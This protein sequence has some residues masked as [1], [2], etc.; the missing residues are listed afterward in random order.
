[1]QPV[2][3]AGDVGLDL[4]DQ[5]VQFWVGLAGE[6]EAATSSNNSTA[7]ARAPVPAAGQFSRTASIGCGPRRRGDIGSWHGDRQMQNGVRLTFDTMR[8]TA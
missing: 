6:G 5:P 3:V 1:M 2:D 4:S 7:K 8:R